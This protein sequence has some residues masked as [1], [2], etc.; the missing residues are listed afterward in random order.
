MNSSLKSTTLTVAITVLLSVT[1]SWVAGAKQ[2]TANTTKIESLVKKVN[3]IEV[4]EE[5]ES[6]AENRLT[7]LEVQAKTSFYQIGRIDKSLIK[8]D[9]K[10][11]NVQLA[12]A[13]ITTAL[14]QFTG[15]VKTLTNQTNKLSNVV[16]RLDERV[17]N[18]EGGD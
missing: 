4:L 18:L 5:K 6:L 15:V 9:D 1:G 8:Y 11:Q 12:S 3:Q 14:E 16:S 17:K 10:I 7:I 2:Q 13:K